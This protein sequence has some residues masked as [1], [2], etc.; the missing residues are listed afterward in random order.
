MPI[1]AVLLQLLAIDRMYI[2]IRMST[3]R[4]MYWMSSVMSMFWNSSLPTDMAH[5]VKNA[6][7]T[8]FMQ[9]SLEQAVQ[10]E[11]GRLSAVAL[12]SKCRKLES[13]SL[14]ADVFEKYE[15]EIRQLQVSNPMHPPVCVLRSNSLP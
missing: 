11:E 4:S 14:F 13:E 10:L 1:Q 3:V 6:C 8:L 7:L 9:S 5:R 12:R 2:P 15:E